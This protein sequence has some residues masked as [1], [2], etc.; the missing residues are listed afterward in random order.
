MDLRNVYNNKENQDN[1]KEEKMVL[2]DYDQDFQD[3]DY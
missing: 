3:Y 2:N 1:I